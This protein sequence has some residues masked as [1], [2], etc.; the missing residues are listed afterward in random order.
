MV[1]N[2]NYKK[3]LILSS[4]ISFLVGPLILEIVLIITSILFLKDEKKEILQN[5]LNNIFF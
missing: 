2:L 3:I 4:P 1:K 5:N